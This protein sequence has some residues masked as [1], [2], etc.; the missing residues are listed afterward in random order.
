MLKFIEN[1]LVQDKNPQ[2]LYNMHIQNDKNITNIHNSALKLYKIAFIDQN[3]SS[4][5]LLFSTYG[6]N[7]YI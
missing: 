7:I 2:Q 6:F 1:V 4:T 5:S 3:S